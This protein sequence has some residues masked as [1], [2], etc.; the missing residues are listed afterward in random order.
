LTNIDFGEGAGVEVEHVPLQSIRPWP[1]N[2]GICAYIGG[3]P[4]HHLVL[5]DVG[6]WGRVGP[7]GSNQRLGT[8]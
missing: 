4:R 5:E 6:Y 8:R 3:R 2:D 7:G 1:E